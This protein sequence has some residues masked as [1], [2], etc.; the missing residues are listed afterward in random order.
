LQ[1]EVAALKLKI[2]MLEFEKLGCPRHHDKGEKDGKVAATVNILRSGRLT[3][4]RY[5]F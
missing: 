4:K 5:S 3:R 1:K 2:V